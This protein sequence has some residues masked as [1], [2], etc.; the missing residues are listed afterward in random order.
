MARASLPDGREG[1]ERDFSRFSGAISVH[2]DKVW[3]GEMQRTLLS[4]EC[5]DSKFLIDEFG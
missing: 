3:A 4:Y 5:L 1:M 2:A